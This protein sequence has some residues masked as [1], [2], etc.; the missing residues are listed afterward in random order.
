VRLP[1]SEAG[2]FSTEFKNTSPQLAEIEEFSNETDADD[3]TTITS[4]RFQPEVSSLATNDAP[5]AFKESIACLKP[6][7]RNI[8]ENLSQRPYKTLHNRT[9]NP[10]WPLPDSG[11]DFSTSRQRDR[12]QR[13]GD[14][15]G[16]GPRPATTRLEIGR[17]QPTRSRNQSRQSAY[18]SVCSS[19][20]SSM[21]SWA[22][23]SSCI[24]EAL[25]ASDSTVPDTSSMMFLIW[26]QRLISKAR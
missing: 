15:T 24:S 14:I 8:V 11:G 21:V 6:K 16:T 10:P 9:S 19:M 4:A 12:L 1:G 5:S 2:Y 23:I 26:K 18:S 13:F 25:A 22:T 3:S 20:N 7:P 17:N